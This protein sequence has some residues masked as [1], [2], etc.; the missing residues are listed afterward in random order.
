[1]TD[2]EKSL[3]EQMND[4]CE[5]ALKRISELIHENPNI[6]VEGFARALIFATG[7]LLQIVESQTDP[8]CHGCAE[9][10]KKYAMSVFEAA[11]KN[12]LEAR[13]KKTE[14]NRR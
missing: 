13:K 8:S 3:E 6:S 14:G 1:M 4:E 5:I 9:N 2:D 11:I 10:A 12:G 7:T